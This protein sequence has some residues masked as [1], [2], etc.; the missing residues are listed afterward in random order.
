M[1]LGS[2]ATKAIASPTGS[3]HEYPHSAHAADS[4]CQR[5]GQPDRSAA[6]PTP[7]PVPRVA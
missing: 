3:D 6:G 2:A 4:G 7:G 5:T 1:R